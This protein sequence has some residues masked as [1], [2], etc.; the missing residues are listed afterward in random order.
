[1]EEIVWGGVTGVVV[2]G[3]VVERMDV[4]GKETELMSVKKYIGLPCA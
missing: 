2:S 1:M 3:G 4:V